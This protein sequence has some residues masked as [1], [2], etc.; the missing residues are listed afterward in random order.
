[1]ES[2]STVGYHL[3]SVRKA[4]IKRKGKITR[5]GG[6]GPLHSVGWNVNGAAALENSVEFLIKLPPTP[7]L[8]IHQK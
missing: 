8:G 3:T 6:G 7:L 4:I 2:Y 5:D 1:V